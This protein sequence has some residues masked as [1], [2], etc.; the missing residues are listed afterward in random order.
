MN[1]IMNGFKKR[2]FSTKA[3][4]PMLK[5]TILLISL[6][7]TAPTGCAE[8]I[9]NNS[10]FF[11]KSYIDTLDGIVVNGIVIKELLASIKKIMYIKNGQS[12]ESASISEMLA[13]EIQNPNDPELIKALALAKKY[14]VNNNKDLLKKIEPAKKLIINLVQEFCE[15]R[16]RPNSLI[17]I[18][19]KASAGTESKVFNQEIKNFDDFNSFLQDLD[20]FLRDLVNSCPKAREQYKQWY[21]KN[22]QFAAL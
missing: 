11:T 22:I 20:L 8:N 21:K 17:L 7:L 6:M 16:N 19:T 10:C 5:K 2:I 4:I 18:W 1:N 14:F 13:R 9:T 3:K 15:R 12:N